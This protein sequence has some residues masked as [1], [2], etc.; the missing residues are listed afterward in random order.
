MEDNR[1]HVLI[2]LYIT[3]A[4]ALS[5]T[6]DCDYEWHYCI[7]PALITIKKEMIGKNPS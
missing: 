5:A 2:L 7:W 6:T 1:G 4:D 3:H